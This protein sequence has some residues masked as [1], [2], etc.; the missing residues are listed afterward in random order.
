M[1]S[2]GERFRKY[3]FKRGMN[4]WAESFTAAELL[5]HSGVNGCGVRGRNGGLTATRGTN[6]ILRYIL[7]L[8]SRGFLLR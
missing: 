2:P 4:I 5:G 1:G 3:V 7:K 6:A 8:F